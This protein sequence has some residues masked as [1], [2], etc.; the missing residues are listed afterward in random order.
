MTLNNLGFYLF[1]IVN[2]LEILLIVNF[3]LSMTFNN[4]GFVFIIY[5]NININDKINKKFTNIQ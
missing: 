3:Y 1:K 4:L 2:N 5:I